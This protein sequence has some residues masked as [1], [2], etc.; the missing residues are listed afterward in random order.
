MSLDAT[1]IITFLS[2]FTRCTA[3]VLSS[4]LFGTNVPVKVRVLFCMVLSLALVPVL[5]EHT[6]TFEPASASAVA[7]CSPSPVAPPVTTLT[8]LLR[9]NNCF[10]VA[11]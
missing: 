7:I 10:M 4:P 8:R 1:L 2:A 11:M 3:M 9:S 5:R 6:T